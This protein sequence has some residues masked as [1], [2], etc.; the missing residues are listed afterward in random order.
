MLIK[1][2]EY[3][4]IKPNNDDDNPNQLPGIPWKGVLTN[5]YFAQTSFSKSICLTKNNTGNG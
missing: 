2:N 5:F 1:G 4:S 3:W